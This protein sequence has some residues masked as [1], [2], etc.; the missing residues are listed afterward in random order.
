MEVRFSKKVEVYNLYVYYTYTLYVCVLLWF[1]HNIYQVVYTSSTSLM[2]CSHY[3][4]QNDK[5]AER[6]QLHCRRVA[7]E[8]LLKHSLT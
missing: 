7:V 8:V 4:Q 1:T 2:V 3:E 5:R 6:G